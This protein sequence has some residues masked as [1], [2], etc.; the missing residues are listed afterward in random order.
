MSNEH[1]LISCICVTNNRPLLLQRSIA[2]FERQEYP[3]KELVVSYPKADMNTKNVIDQIESLSDI[4][5]VRIER[6]EEDNLGQARNHAVS[7]ANGD[8][9]CIWDDDDWY[10]HDRLEV[11]YN[12]IKDGP[13]KASVIMNILLYDAVSK[14]GFYS[15]YRHWEGS[16]LCEK[17][18]LLAGSYM[19]LD[20]GEDTS[21]LYYLSSHNVLYHI[22]DASHM[23]IY[24][25]HGGNTWGE[26]HFNSYFL[27]SQPL[28]ESVNKQIEDLLDLSY[29]LI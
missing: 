13:F 4:K 7:A 28:N 24:V 19:E 27:E 3:N 9:V 26:N 15:P 20:K 1:P 16:L 18:T 6:S 12:V 22:M 8:F 14:E 25:Y 23:Y 2:C 21:L 10:N 17:A 5:I 29:Y 11:Q